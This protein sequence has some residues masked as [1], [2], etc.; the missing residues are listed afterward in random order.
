LAN[1]AQKIQISFGLFQKL[2]KVK[3]VER[4]PRITN[5]ASQKPNWQPCP[6]ARVEPGVLRRIATSCMRCVR[7]NNLRCTLENHAAGRNQWPLHL[8]L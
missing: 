5:L 4:K 3:G 2:K 7:S 8:G 1:E 6:F